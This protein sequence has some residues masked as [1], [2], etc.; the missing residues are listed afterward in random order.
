MCDNLVGDI[1]GPDKKVLLQSQVG[2][3]TR[4]AISSLVVSDQCVTIFCGT[5]R[6]ASEL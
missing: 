3:G 5:H 2:W 6:V 1:R 4:L